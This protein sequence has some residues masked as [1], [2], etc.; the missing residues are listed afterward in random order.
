[1]NI[2]GVSFSGSHESAACLV[3]D[4]DLVFACAEERLSRRKQ[5]SA[6]PM[7]A[8]QAAL[9]FAGLKPSDVDHVAFSW[10]RPRELY[11]HNLRLLL[12]GRWPSSAIHRDMLR[13]L[14][15]EWR[16]N[17]RDRDRWP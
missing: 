15:E 17:L 6:V 13:P 3:Q 16:P 5:D 7:R 10:P 2:L 14:D 11:A 1:M 9:D 4:G 8:I 12:S